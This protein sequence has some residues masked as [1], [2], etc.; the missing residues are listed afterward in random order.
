MRPYG[1]SSLLLIG[2]LAAA[3][4][5]GSSEP[6]ALQSGCLFTYR[7]DLKSADFKGVRLM[8]DYQLAL[9]GKP[10]PNHE[11]ESARAAA[12][13]FGRFQEPPLGKMP[14]CVSE[15]YRLTWVPSFH[16]TTIVRVWS[17]ND[18][19]FITIKRLDRT[20]E[21]RNGNHYTETTRP[22]TNAEWEGTIT[23]INAYDFWNISSAEKEPI[24]NDGASWLIEGNRRNQYHNVFRLLPAPNLI[25]IIRHMVAL[26]GEDAEVDLYLPD[27]AQ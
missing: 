9:Q 1:F 19:Q 14:D 24:P 11:E 10:S 26:T 5:C 16:R 20:P 25:R 12:D 7:E 15:A 8:P 22:L 13:F 17:S 18:G 21:N 3:I 23:L 4:S 6:V 2:L 27:E